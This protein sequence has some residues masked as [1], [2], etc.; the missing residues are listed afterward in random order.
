[1]RKPLAGF[2]ALLM[3]LVGA[4]FAL[5]PTSTVAAESDCDYNPTTTSWAVI[6]HASC[7]LGVD[8]DIPIRCVAG[9]G[10]SWAELEQYDSHMVGYTAYGEE[11]SGI[12]WD[13][14]YVQHKG[15]HNNY[16]WNDN[17]H[18]VDQVWVRAG[19]DLSCL[20]EAGT[21][22]NRKWKGDQQWHNV[23]NNGFV[24]YCRVV[25]NE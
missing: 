12:W 5:T 20:N 18:G 15:C 22:W 21:A 4:V 25:A 2:F 7:D 8:D 1:M 17:D 24:Y 16:G 9:D 23:V 3:L 19:Q 6:V 10:S 11:S 13:E 14:T